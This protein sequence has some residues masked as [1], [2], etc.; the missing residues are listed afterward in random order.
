MSYFRFT[1]YLCL[2]ICLTRAPFIWAWGERGHDSIA[3]VAVRSLKAQK[4]ATKLHFFLLQKEHLLG[5]LANV[6][7]IV[8]RNLDQETE[9]LNAPTHYLDI[10]YLG[11]P[12]N[13]D[14][15]PKSTDEQLRLIQKL[16]QQPTSLSKCPYADHAKQP[17]PPSAAETSIFQQQLKATDAGTA[18]YR[19]EQLFRMLVSSF[20][21]AHKAQLKTPFDRKSFMMALNQA[22]EYGGLMGHFV[23]DLTNPLHTTYDFDGYETQQGGIHHYFETLIVNELDLGVE[24]ETLKALTISGLYTK[25]FEKLIKRTLPHIGL[26]S[27]SFTKNWI[28][29]PLLVALALTIESHSHLDE[30][31]KLD[32]SHALLTKSSQKG[33]LKIP[34]SRKPPAQAAPSLRA[35]VIERLAMGSAVLSHLWLEAYKQGG[36]PDLSQYQSFHYPVAPAFIPVESK[37]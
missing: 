6:P 29:D 21:E 15:F 8:W 17:G 30:I 35:F 34:A 31:K 25:P 13:I 10:E 33:G 11:S 1:S 20:Q 12:A 37:I 28:S 32:R 7:D 27:S 18:P 22:L 3:R 19:I 26:P 24:M 14:L 4:E 9:R 36:Q 23:G 2:F 16:C 5:H